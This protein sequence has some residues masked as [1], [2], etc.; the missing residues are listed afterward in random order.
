MSNTLEYI[1]STITTSC[2]FPVNKERAQKG[3]FLVCLQ[4][5]VMKAAFHV[6]IYQQQQQQ[7]RAPT[8]GQ[9]SGAANCQPWLLSDILGYCCCWSSGN[10]HQTEQASDISGLDAL[11]VVNESGDIMEGDEMP[12]AA[13]LLCSSARVLSCRDTGVICSDYTQ[14]APV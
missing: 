7:D 1:W 4:E 6:H 3:F 10:L 2:I 8:T 12:D 14:P 9:A 11:P 5:F 13:Q